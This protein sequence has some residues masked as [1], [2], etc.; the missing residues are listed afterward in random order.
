MDA[1]LP[2]FVSRGGWVILLGFLMA[3]FFLWSAF[4]F[5]KR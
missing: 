5:R 3:A 2:L 4:R 1:L